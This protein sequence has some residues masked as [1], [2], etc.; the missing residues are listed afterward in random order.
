MAGNFVNTYGDVSI[1]EDVVLNA[2]EI[3]TAKE[4]QVMN[5]LGKTS[6]IATVHSYLTDTL[7]T[8]ASAA[9]SEE[10]DFSAS[11]QTT[12]TRKTNLV[13][14]VAIPF[15]VSRTQQQVLHYQ[16]ENELERQQRKALMDWANAFEFDLVRSSLVS[17]VSGTIPKMQGIIHHTSLAKNH[18]S[19]TS[20]TIFNASHLEGL[21]KNQW[22]QSNGD[23]ATD[24]LLSSG[25]RKR[26]DDATQKS[27]VVVNQANGLTNIV[28]MTSTYSTAFGTV[29]VHTHRYVFQSG[30]DATDQILGI[31]RRKGNVAWLKM[32]YV[33]ND[34][35][36]SGDYD[37]KAVVGK[38]TFE[39]VNDE[40]FFFSNGFLIE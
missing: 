25:T 40:S 9:V 26:L 35:A 30:T 28:K 36:R 27:N 12:P 7:R 21:M 24:L 33:D 14:I 18:T 13:Q 22:N 37:I 4:T 8:A 2:V 23:T 19:H 20:G 38:G 11:G 6:A 10:G 1:R 16:G 5:M 29:T 17:G 31:N 32:P 39:C 15:K 3:L 34:L